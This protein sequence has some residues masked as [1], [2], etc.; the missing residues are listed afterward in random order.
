[1]NDLRRIERGDDNRRGTA[2][3]EE[4]EPD[5]VATL[6][7][8]VQAHPSLARDLARVARELQRT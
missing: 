6:H 5:M 1:M 2:D 7:A 3:D 8:L 4:D